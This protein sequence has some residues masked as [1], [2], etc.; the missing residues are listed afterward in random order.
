MDNYLYTVN[1][2]I[3]VSAFKVFCFTWYETNKLSIDVSINIFQDPHSKSSDTIQ[4][5]PQLSRIK[6]SKIEKLHQMK[7]N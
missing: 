7:A 3:L 1:C 6:N 4:L 5:K 2:K